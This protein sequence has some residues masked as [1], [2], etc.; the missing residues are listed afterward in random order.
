MQRGDE[1]E[2]EIDASGAVRVVTHNVKGKRCL[3]YV[4]IF[5]EILGEAKQESLTP[6]YNQVDVQE[7]TV[8]HVSQQV[9][10]KW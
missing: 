5:Q 6:E 10:R 2:I 3:E 8:S 9:K 4:E 1:L 7:E